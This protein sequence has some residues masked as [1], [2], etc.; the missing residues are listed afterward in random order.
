MPVS[1]DVLECS[2]VPGTVVEL[3]R[4]HEGHGSGQKQEGEDPQHQHPGS[5]SSNA[6]HFRQ[7]DSISIFLFRFCVG[8]YDEGWVS[9]RGNEGPEASSTVSSCFGGFYVV[10]L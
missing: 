1:N 8:S 4:H 7:I 5:H 2:L 9:H 6:R 3:I 10:F